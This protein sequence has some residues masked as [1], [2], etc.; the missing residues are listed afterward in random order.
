MKKCVKNEEIHPRIEREK[1]DVQKSVQNAYKIM[2]ETTP[3]LCKT[4]CEKIDGMLTKLATLKQ[5]LFK[6][7]N[8]FFM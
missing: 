5:N 6:T 2:S 8:S 4:K 1:R 3:S 7:F